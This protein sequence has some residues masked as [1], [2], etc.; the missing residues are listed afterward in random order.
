MKVFDLFC[1]TGGFSKGFEDSTKK[2]DFNV[3]FGLDLLKPSVETFKLNHKTALGLCQDIR[4]VKKNEISEIL[5]IKKNEIGII[6]G[7]PPCQGFSSIRP[8]RSSNDD[9]P[10]NTLF[11]EYASFVNFFRPK[12]FVLENVVGIATHKKGESLDIMQQCFH[13][14][15]YDTDWKLLNA[16]HFGVPQKRER[17]IMIGVERGGKMV[18]PEPTHRYKGAT[19]GYKDK[20]KRLLP[21]EYD[22]FNRK[23]LPKAITVME[24]ID[25]LPPIKSGEIAENY[26]LSPRTNYQKKR[27][28]GN[29]ILK[30]H[31]STKHTEKMLEIIK[32]AGKNI[33]CIPKN[34]I[35]SGFSSC[36]S[37]LDA[38]EPAVTITVNFVHPASN[39]CIHPLL[40]RAL[41]P[42][43]GAR[44]Q[45][46]DDD[47]DFFG[48]RTQ[49][50]KQIGNAVPPLLGRSIADALAEFVL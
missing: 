32:H 41:T 39:R 29:E 40:N 6:I 46:F 15:G 31:S 2:I 7:G 24:A 12:C 10:R 5:K 48:N 36:Y 16:A 45:S 37:R 30:L 19:I 20:S 43:E 27:R 22:L 21:A 38:N 11:E 47:F 3:V 25:D 44:L 28:N 1:G 23:E 49:I 8:F 17:F 34:L 9:D 35:S 42:R 13:D 33:N 50:T 26:S 18:F 4:K 14:I